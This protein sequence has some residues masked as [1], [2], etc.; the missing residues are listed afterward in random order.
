MKT[1]Y[2]YI[3]NNNNYIGVEFLV[4][5]KRLSLLKYMSIFSIIREHN[6]TKVTI[7]KQSILVLIIPIEKQEKFIL[8]NKKRQM[9]F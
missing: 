3:Y 1:T 9:S 6:P 4:E 7:P 8:I 5:K 2:N